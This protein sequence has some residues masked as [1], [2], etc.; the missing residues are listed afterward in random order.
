VERQKRFKENAAGIDRVMQFAN[1]VS[2]G[3]A[4]RGQI[5]F[6]TE[7]LACR[8]CHSMKPGEVLVGP[9]LASVGIQRQP[10]DVLESIVTPNSKI[11]EGFETAVLELDSGKVVTG[12]VRREDDK[13]IELVDAEAK[14]TAIDVASIENRIKG[15]SAMPDNVVENL[16]PRAL[17]DLLAYLMQQRAPV[18]G[19]GA[20]ASG[21]HE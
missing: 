15:K 8:R 14:K 16:S 5:V 21:R 19:D 9:S 18:T 6:E 17:R 3:D 4:D 1:C 10:L 2:G 20:A 7:S 11:V 13:R 12:I